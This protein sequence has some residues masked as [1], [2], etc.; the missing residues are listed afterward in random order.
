MSKVVLLARRGAVEGV[1][2]A[3]A[4]GLIYVIWRYVLFNHLSTVFFASPEAVFRKIGDWWDSG[5]L[6]P[7]LKT[8]LTVATSGLGIAI[9]LGLT[10]GLTIGLA[11]YLVG[12]VLEPIVIAI[13]A[14]PKLALVPVLF[15]ALGSGFTPRVVLIVLAS[16]PVIAIFTVTGIRTVD[17]DATKMMQLFGS[18]R[19]QIGAKLFLPHA[20]GY[21]MTAVVLEAPHAVTMAIGAEILF[22]TT[23]GIGGISNVASASFDAAGVL[24]AVVV[25]TVLCAT[26]IALSRLAAA[27]LVPLGNEAATLGRM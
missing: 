27:R 11:P 2:W 1:R 10:L 23:G 13:Y 5:K 19:L 20:M 7:I 24:A 3:L 6:L 9:C 21:F 25:G 17:P 22:G 8:T 14:M 15:V 26:A 12:K 16:V 18:S 4:V